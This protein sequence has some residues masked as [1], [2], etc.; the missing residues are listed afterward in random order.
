[1]IHN[2]YID[3]SPA[4]PERGRVVPACRHCRKDTGYGTHGGCLECKKVQTPNGRKARKA[5]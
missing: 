4:V 2:R 1:M 5:E 3:R